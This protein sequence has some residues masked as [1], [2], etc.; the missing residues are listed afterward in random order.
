LYANFDQ[1][2]CSLGHECGTV[3][4][5]HELLPCDRYETRTDLVGLYFYRRKIKIFVPNGPKRPKRKAKSVHIRLLLFRRRQVMIP[6]TIKTNRCILF[7]GS[8]R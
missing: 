2:T 3:T 5:V 4:A 1:G 7:F 6:I 8:V